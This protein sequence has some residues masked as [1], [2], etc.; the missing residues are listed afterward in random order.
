MGE[1]RSLT[2]WGDRGVGARLVLDSGEVLVV[3]IAAGTVRLT[4]LRRR[5]FV[6]FRPRLIYEV[7]TRA[8]YAP[9]ERAVSVSERPFLDGPDRPS[10]TFLKWLVSILVGLPTANAA[11]GALTEGIGPSIRVPQR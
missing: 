3:S 10:G 5:F 1:V 7:S 2:I 9:Y 4:E 8:A 11:V 6:L